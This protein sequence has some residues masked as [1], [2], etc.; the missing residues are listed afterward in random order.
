MDAGKTLRVSTRSP[1]VVHWTTNDWSSS[2]DTAATETGIG[3][4]YSD[5][6]TRQLRAGA[7]VRFTLYWIEARR[8]E[9][10]DFVITVR[11]AEGAG[12]GAACSSDENRTELAEAAAP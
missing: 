8:W 4:W 10:T 7:T 6:P 3:I 2:H 12:L 5:L 11:G 1:A 9:G